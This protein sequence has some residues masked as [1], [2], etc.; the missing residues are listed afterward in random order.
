LTQGTGG[1]R[2]EKQNFFQCAVPDTTVNS[3]GEMTGFYEPGRKTDKRQQQILRL[4]RRMTT[5]KQDDASTPAKASA[6]CNDK[7]DTS[8]R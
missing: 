8:V 7:D 3:F 2:G 4:R 5:K 1:W 6:T